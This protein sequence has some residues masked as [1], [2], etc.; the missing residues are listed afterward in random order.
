[1]PATVSSAIEQRRDRG[2]GELE[3]KKSASSAYVQENKDKE[4][5]NPSAT[6]IDGIRD[7]KLEIA[8]EQRKQRSREAVIKKTSNKLSQVGI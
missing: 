4:R 8:I 5:E 1:M 3:R 7:Q 6:E 2:V